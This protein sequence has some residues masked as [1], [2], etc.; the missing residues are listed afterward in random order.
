MSNQQS[1]DLDRL[2]DGYLENDLSD[3]EFKM[4]QSQLENDE[5]ARKSLLNRVELDAMLFEHFATT[6]IFASLPINWGPVPI[7]ND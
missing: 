1:S 6:N 5:S 2:I 7:L 4:L 3:Q